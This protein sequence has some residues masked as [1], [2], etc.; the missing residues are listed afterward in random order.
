[1]EVR[2][3]LYIPPGCCICLEPIWSHAT[4]CPHCDQCIHTTCLE[5]WKKTLAPSAG[6]ADRKLHA[7]RDA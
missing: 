3:P 6:N 1:M 7:F 5:K 2:N 4:W